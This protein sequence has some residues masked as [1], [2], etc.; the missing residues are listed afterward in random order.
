MSPRGLTLRELSM[1]IVGAAEFWGMAFGMGAAQKSERVPYNP[2]V[3]Q[4]MQEAKVSR[5]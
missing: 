3:L 4:A 5:G 2:A 1:M